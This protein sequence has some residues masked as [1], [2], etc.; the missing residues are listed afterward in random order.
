MSSAKT[1]EPIEMQFRAASRWPK[2]P[3]ITWGRD[4]PMEVDNFWVLFGPLKCI[5]S[6]CCGVCSK[7]DH[8][9]VS[10]GMQLK[11]IIQS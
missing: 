10:D 11:G 5:G 3:C 6:H 4:P 1:A 7:R 9:V 2:E 8:S